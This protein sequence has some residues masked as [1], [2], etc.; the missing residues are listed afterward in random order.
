M[1]TMNDSTSNASDDADNVITNQVE[2]NNTG[3]VAEA[4]VSVEEEG[5]EDEEGEESG[6]SEDDDDD[7]DGQFNIFVS[8]SAEFVFSLIVLKTKTKYGGVR[9]EFLI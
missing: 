1:Q 4:S 7:D 6:S 9:G 3:D 2:E 5:E 8:S